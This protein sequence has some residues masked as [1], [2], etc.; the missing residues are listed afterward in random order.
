M[1]S[2]ISHLV[3]HDPHHSHKAGEILIQ[4]STVNPENNLILLTEIDS[5]TE[6]DYLFIEQLIN[7]ACQTLENEKLANAEK[8]LETILN[9]VNEL[10]PQIM[11]KQKNWLNR[12]HC[13]IA[14][15]SEAKLYFSTFGKIGVFLVRPTVIKKITSQRD[16]ESETKIFSYTLSGELKQ[17]DKLLI[18][19]ASLTNFISL[20]KIKK[21][22]STLPPKSAV[23]HLNNI[24][25]ST[26]PEISFF[27]T[28]LQSGRTADEINEVEALRPTRLSAPTTSKNSID[29]LIS[30]GKETE[31]ILTPP[32]LFQSLAEKLRQRKSEPKS[33]YGI[34]IGNSE[35][36]HGK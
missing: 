3:I 5:N 30:L 32:S 1:P 31:K 19:T 36:Q 23:A 26:P 6:Q 35:Y 21:I 17:D 2:K 28:I 7:L 34:I 14:I 22:I 33:S 16:N 15:F 24:L 27:F 8:T 25:Q 12:F 18:S 20:D 13:L 4:P 10:V 29:Q 11:P 9:Q